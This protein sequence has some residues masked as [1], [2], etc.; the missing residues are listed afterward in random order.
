MDQRIFSLAVQDKLLKVYLRDFFVDSKGYYEPE[1]ERLEEL[2]VASLLLIQA[3]LVKEQTQQSGKNTFGNL[4]LLA[5]VMNNLITFY[6]EVTQY[7]NQSTD[8]GFR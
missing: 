6:S 5:P 3:Y 2:R 4:L 1:K 7:G 8:V